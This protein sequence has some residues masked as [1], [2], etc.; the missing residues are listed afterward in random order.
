M[1]LKQQAQKDGEYRKSELIRL[2]LNFYIQARS[3]APACGEMAE[4][5]KTIDKAETFY[6]ELSVCEQVVLM[7]DTLQPWSELVKMKNYE[8]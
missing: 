4:M 1:T 8:K 6:S 7:Q 5:L 3:G 2:A